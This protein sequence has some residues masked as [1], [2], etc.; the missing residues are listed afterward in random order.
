MDEQTTAKKLE[1]AEKHRKEAEFDAAAAI[2]DEILKKVP[3]NKKALDG[4]K[5]LQEERRRL[6][7]LLARAEKH[8]KDN[9]FDKAIVMLDKVLKQ[10]PHLATALQGKREAQEQKRYDAKIKELLQKAQEHLAAGDYDEANIALNQAQTIGAQH[11]ILYYHGQIDRLRD[12]IELQSVSRQKLQEALAQAEQ[13]EKEGKIDEALKVLNETLRRIEEHGLD[14]GDEARAMRDRLLGDKKLRELWDEASTAYES[15]DFKRAYELSTSLCEDDPADRRCKLIRDAWEKFKKRLDEVQEALAGDRLDDAVVLLQELRNQAP[16]NPDWKALWLKGY[17]EHGEA[18]FADGRRLLESYDFQEAAQAFGVARDAFAKVLEVFPTH[19][20]ML[21][22][23]QEAEGLL[24]VSRLLVQAQRDKNALRIPAAQGELEQAEA[25]IKEVRAVRDRD[26]GEVQFVINGMMSELNRLGSDIRKAQTAL[27]EG[28]AALA[29]HEPTLAEARFREGL[30]M[31]G[32]IPLDDLRDDLLRGMRLSQRIVKKAEALLKKADKEEALDKKLKLL[33]KAQEEWPGKPGLAAKIAETR[34]ALCEEASAAGN[35]K[36]AAQ[37]CT[38]ASQMEEAPASIRERADAILEE[39][40]CV[41]RLQGARAELRKRQAAVQAA[42]APSVEMHQHLADLLAK[43]LKLAQK[44]GADVAPALQEDLEKSKQALQRLKQSAVIFEKSRNAQKAGQWQ[45]A[46]AFYEEALQKLGDLASPAQ[47]EELETLKKAGQQITGGM[48]KARELLATV[49]KTYDQAADAGILKAPW[50]EMLDQLNQAAAAL[51]AL[52]SQK[53]GALPPEWAT[54]H[55]DVSEM[56]KLVEKLHQIQ[57]KAVSQDMGDVMEAI[58]GLQTLEQEWPDDAVLPALSTSLLAAKQDQM[59]QRLEKLLSQVRSSFYDGKF[60]DAKGKLTELQRLGKGDAEIQRVADE[61]ERQIEIWEEFNLAATGAYQKKAT[62]SL[63]DALRGYEEAFGKILSSESGLPK[64]ILYSLQQLFSINKTDLNKEESK[65]IYENLYSQLLDSEFGY[66]LS[67]QLKDWFNLARRFASGAFVSSMMQM[68]E[69]EG[70]YRAA[71]EMLQEYPDDEAVI[72][73]TVDA[74]EKLSAQLMDSTRKRISRA[75]KLAEDGA[76]ATAL[77]ELEEIETKVIGPVEK[78]F[79]E[80]IPEDLN[81]LRSQAKAFMEKLNNLASTLQKLNPL[82]EDAYKALTADDL[83]AA[84]A[85]IDKANFIDRQHDVKHIWQEL[86]EYQKRIEERKQENLRI[87]VRQAL[88]AIETRLEVTDDPEIVKTELQKLEALQT[89]ID[90]LQGEKGDSLRKRYQKN[91]AE[92]RTRLKKLEELAGIRQTIEK[93]E[94]IEGKLNALRRAQEIVRGAER[95]EFTLEIERLEKELQ[96]QKIIEEAWM[97][98]LA[99]MSARRYQEALEQID[100]AF[101]YGKPGPSVD[102]YRCAAEIGNRL[103]PLEEQLLKGDGDLEAISRSLKW[104]KRDVEKCADCPPE[105]DDCQ[106]RPADDIEKRIKDWLEEVTERLQKENLLATLFNEIELALSEQRFDDA[107]A[108]MQEIINVSP[109]DARIPELRK[110][111]NDIEKA[112]RLLEQ[113]KSK[114]ASGQYDSAIKTAEAALKAYPGFSDAEILLE[115]AKDDREAG[116]ALNRAKR[117]AETQRFVEARAEL[118]K[119]AEL[120]SDHPQ[121]DKTLE[122]IEQKERDYLDR[123]LRPMRQPL[124]KKDF[125]RAWTLF[126][127]GLKTFASSGLDTNFEYQEEMQRVQSEILTQ[128]IATVTSKTEKALKSPPAPDNVLVKLS[129]NIQ[130][131]MNL[132]DVLQDRQRRDLA[133]LQERID[134]VRVQRRLK[135]GRDALEEGDM[136]KAAAISKELDEKI[137]MLTNI[138]LINEIFKFSEDVE[139]A[140]NALLQEKRNQTLAEVRALLSQ[141]QGLDDLRKALKSLDKVITPSDTEDID[142]S[143]LR[144]EIEHEIALFE[145]TENALKN[146]KRRI[147]NN[148]YEQASFELT[149]I[150]VSHLLQDQVTAWRQAAQNLIDAANQEDEE[151]ETALAIYSKVA[152]TLPELKN[153]VAADIRRCQEILFEQAVEQVQAWLTPTDPDPEKALAL[154][155]RIAERGW[156]TDESQR[157]EHQELLRLAQNLQALDQAVTAIKND[158]PASGLATLNRVRDQIDAPDVLDIVAGWQDVAHL[159]Q[160][161]N[162]DDLIAAQRYAAEIPPILQENPFVS[163]LFQRLANQQSLVAEFDAWEEQITQGLLSAT[164][165]WDQ[166]TRVAKAAWSRLRPP[167]PRGRLL[168]DRVSQALQEVIADLQER[169]AFAELLTPLTHLR[170]LPEQDDKAEQLRDDA[171]AAY[172]A[173]LTKALDAAEKDIKQDDLARGQAHLESAQRLLLPAGSFFVA[174]NE[175]NPFRSRLAELSAQLTQREEDLQEVQALVAKAQAALKESNYEQATDHALNAVSLAP[176]YRLVTDFI[177][178]LLKRLDGLT[179][180]ARTADRLTEALS[181][182]DL[183]LRLSNDEAY[184]RLRRQLLEEQKQKSTALARQAS[185]ALAIFDLNG[186][187]KAIRKGKLVDAV[188]AR[189]DSLNQRLSQAKEVSKQLRALMIEGWEHLH[190]RSFERSLQSFDRAADLTPD[191]TEPA[192]WR[193]YVANMIDGVN[194]AERESRYLKPASIKFDEAANALRWHQS[195][196]LSPL[197]GKRLEQERRTAIYYAMRLAQEMREMDE[198]WRK[199]DQLANA[200]AYEES[201]RLLEQLQN[202]K[203]RFPD[204][205]HTAMKPPA[206]F[207]PTIKGGYTP[208]S[209]GGGTSS[210]PDSSGWKSSQSVP[211]KTT[212]PA[213]D[214]DAGADDGHKP[215]KAVPKPTR[216]ANPFAEDAIDDPDDAAPPAAPEKKAEPK[217][218]SPPKPGNPFGAQQDDSP[219]EPVDSIKTPPRFSPPVTPPSSHEER[220]EEKPNA[221]PREM[222]PDEEI[223]EQESSAQQAGYDA[224]HTDA[225]LDDNA[226]DSIFSPEQEQDQASDDEEDESMQFNFDD[227]LQSFPSSFDDDDA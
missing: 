116:S 142:I 42:E 136:D 87:E 162:D 29:E 188:D 193:N 20:Q 121:M 140:R 195:Q 124:R 173:A 155:G 75:T 181:Y 57:K 55:H 196:P 139:D 84:Q 34:L 16:N 45:Q 106:K 81:D 18:A 222:E 94:T 69:W 164:P 174:S 99:A 137:E 30:D 24:E 147:R 65:G 225:P 8:Q 35:K 23:A 152:E 211:H 179:R 83:D 100:L 73:N 224:P 165:D 101:R 163:D 48:E 93:A 91:V 183:M 118:A 86:D 133:A 203:A 144:Q 95:E 82:R 56:Q 129:N 9:E 127:R 122:I 192:S 212:P 14:I 134:V 38:A 27:R 80:V 180:A 154:L 58:T 141:A 204:M 115:Q 110:R 119:A 158:D 76:Y 213:A 47:R 219:D 148:A 207:D 61:L 177:A 159:L 214:N 198:L 197:W 15:N 5:A 209:S 149:D 185:E 145:T 77:N 226:L 53:A 71:N 199:T 33:E 182:T 17:R 97:K 46:I 157:M 92:A 70:A 216:T 96:T 146:A 167:H 19:P 60:V 12:E 2:Y 89:D 210:V 3:G 171:L 4:K 90:K 40:D 135:E 150:E 36:L 26:F 202:R 105:A 215:Q 78:E 113:A 112:H 189:F 72:Q 39:I 166:L 7:E 161:L 54:L 205:I 104:L 194:M 200:E 227:F 11:S 85:A 66:I 107:R 102:A 79:P 184:V 63:K 6:N 206:G 108:K 191:F 125:A 10:Y 32:D 74:R 52:R 220:S 103:Q 44:C 217:P 67:P 64:D 123:I 120:K 190:N 143:E 151:P 13:L 153:V 1:Q 98:A 22:A 156:M 51:E 131:V 187:Q 172:H 138:P 88:A 21:A 170:T 109:N 128:W 117:Y 218:S 223:G 43:T 186:A 31:L 169:K 41:K 68:E 160:S 37:Y 28:Q 59:Q 130:D 62:N 111:I 208:P 176:N 25:R 175:D 221:S 50:Q 168:V 49:R 178:T 132:E 114:Y 126:Q 201:L